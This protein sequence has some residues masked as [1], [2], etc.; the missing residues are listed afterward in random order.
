MSVD[1]LI[2]EIGNVAQAHR[3]EALEYAVSHRNLRS[4]K[5]LRDGES[6]EAEERVVPTVQRPGVDNEIVELVG[7][8]NAPPCD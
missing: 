3:G 5:G 6:I 2:S 7:E 1:R 4:S 8:C